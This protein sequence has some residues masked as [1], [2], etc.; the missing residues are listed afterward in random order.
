[1]PPPAPQLSK[2]DAARALDLLTD[3]AL[4]RRQALAAF[5]TAPL[6]SQEDE[7]NDSESPILDSFVQRGGEEAIFSKTNFSRIEFD[8]VRNTVQEY[9]L[10]NWNVGRGRKSGFYGKEVFFYATH[11]IEK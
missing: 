9:V 6:Q 5:P 7:E 2:D 3:S 4:R 11:V 1:M 10:I 8:R